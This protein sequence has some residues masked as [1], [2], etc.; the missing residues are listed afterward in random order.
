M[1]TP[2]IDLNY[3]ENHVY[4]KHLTVWYVDPIKT[5]IKR[6]KSFKYGVTEIFW[7]YRES[8]EFIMLKYSKDFVTIF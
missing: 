2:R 6:V 3:Y 8:M 7:I 4:S 5:D 1:S